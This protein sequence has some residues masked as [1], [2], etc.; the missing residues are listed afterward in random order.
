VEALLQDEALA[1][2]TRL[3]ATLPSLAS[4]ELHRRTLEL[5]TTR[6]APHLGWTPAA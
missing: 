4:P 2:A 6:I 5:I 1:E 3:T